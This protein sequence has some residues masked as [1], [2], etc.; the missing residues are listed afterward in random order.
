MCGLGLS[1]RS[2]SLTCGPSSSGLSL[3]FRPNRDRLL[4]VRTRSGAADLHITEPPWT[5]PRCAES[6][7]G[8]QPW[9][10]S[11]IGTHRL[12]PSSSPPYLFSAPS[13]NSTTKSSGGLGLHYC[14]RRF[15]TRKPCAASSIYR[16]PLPKFRAVLALPR[17]LPGP[18]RREKREDRRRDHV[19]RRHQRIGATPPLRP[20]T[21][22][23]ELRTAARRVCEAL[24]W[25]GCAR[26]RQNFSPELTLPTHPPCSL[27]SVVMVPIAGK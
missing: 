25:A 4:G 14:D 19:L 26:S 2:G 10:P 21:P 11:V 22:R 23:L 5:H 15:S 17:V 13:A 6:V 20:Q 12:E 24:P 18:Q 27:C 8:A 16:A 3:T 7:C 9:S 1:P